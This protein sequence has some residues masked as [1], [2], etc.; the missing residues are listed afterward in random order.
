[1]PTQVNE[2]GQPIGPALSDWVTRPVPL[3]SSLRGRWCLVEPVDVDRHAV[4]LY[5]AYSEAS[6]ARDWTYLPVGPFADLA[7]YR[8][9]LARV[10]ASDDPLHHAIT[11]LASG[12]AIGT[13]ALM[14]V[15]PSNGVI[16]VGH[17]T[18]SRRLQRTAA[19]TEALFLLMQ[20]VFDQLGY[21]RFEWKC[22]HLNAPSRGA[23]LRYGFTFEGIFRQAVIYKERSR[24]T[25]WFA[26]V[27]SDWPRLRAAFEAW[28]KPENFDAAGAQRVSLAAFRSRVEAT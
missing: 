22:D 25:A 11:D 2:Y 17:I 20:R 18:Y 19:G 12:K 4:D 21:R 6:D 15:D 5:E 16:E 8:D 28:L 10:A 3:R 26:I 7:Q 23:A 1:M 13:A 24:D 27:D 14:R 9:Y